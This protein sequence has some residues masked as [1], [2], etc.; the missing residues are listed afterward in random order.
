ME[1]SPPPQSMQQSQPIYQHQ[2]ST[3]TINQQP[4][5]SNVRMEDNYVYSPL[6]QSNTLIQ[7]S[8]PIDKTLATIEEMA[9]FDRVKKFIDD[10]TTYHE[11]LKLLNLFTQDIIDART[12]IDR[13]QLFIGENKELWDFFKAMVGIV[14]GPGSGGPGGTFQVDNI[15][16]IERPKIELEE[17]K[18]YG[19]SYRKLPQSEVSLSCSGRDAMCWEV[20]NDEWVSHPTWASEDSGF[21]AHRKNHFEEALHKSEEERHEYD[22]HIEANLRTIALLEPIA[23]RI[24]AMDN[25]ERSAFRLKPGLGG[26]S[27]SIYQRIIKKVY[28]RENGLEIINALH[29][30]PAVAVPVILNRLK[31]KDEE[32]K[33]AQREWNK[34]WRELDARNFYKSLDH[35]GIVWKSNEKKNLTS[36]QLIIEIET[37]RKEQIQKRK[38]TLNPISSNIGPIRARYQMSFKIED[39]TVLFDAIKLILAFIDRPVINSSVNNVG[40]TSYSNNQSVYSSS[41]RERYETVLRDLIQA[42]FKIDDAKF[43]DNLSPS[44]GLSNSV[45]RNNRNKNNENESSNSQNDNNNNRHEGDEPWTNLQSEQA[46]TLQVNTNSSLSDKSRKHFNFFCNSTYYITFRLFYVSEVV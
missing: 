4:V 24:S 14:P 41:E 45:N 37:L 46:N 36:K 13:S 35:Q 40:T 33:R 44:A 28:G 5:Y 39:E 21:V 43:E 34:V 20:L 3:Q 19:A 22:Y 42:F 11:F 10:K 7:P 2:P 17:C 16:A 27:K 26:Q 6:M 1:M 9:F 30:N 25:E 38:A 29:E 31:A 8:I 18:K 12:L 32:W 23:A 15:P